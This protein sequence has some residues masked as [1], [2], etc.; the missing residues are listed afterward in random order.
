MFDGTYL[1]D[2]GWVFF[3]IWSLIL[4]AFFLVTFGEELFGDPERQSGTAAKKTQ[5]AMRSATPRLP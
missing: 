2:A 5:N 3:A 4:A 1:F